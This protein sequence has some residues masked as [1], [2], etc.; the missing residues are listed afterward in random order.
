MS[1]PVDF[2]IRFIAAETGEYPLTIAMIKAKHPLTSFPSEP[3]AELFE[4]MGYHVV[5]PSAV[6]AGDVVTEV[7]PV[8]GEDGI[9]RQA[10]ESRNFSAEEVSANLQTEQGSRRSSLMMKRTTALEKGAPIDFGGTIGLQHVQLRD[11]DRANIIGLRIDS[12]SAITAGNVDYTGVRTYE[13][14]FVPLTH[15]QMVDLS[16]KV[17]SA[18][19]EIMMISW[20]YEDLIKAAETL[21]EL[22]ALP[23]EIVPTPQAILAP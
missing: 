10:Y 11:G 19:K 15:Q 18:Y 12:E 2:S 3:T 17:L 8:L 1:T 6:P 14:V 21:A 23:E 22:P 4:D 20:N 7:A 9:Y 16:W 13:N 5:Q